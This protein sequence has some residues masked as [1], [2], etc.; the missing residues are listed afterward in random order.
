[1]IFENGI[2][3]L[4]LLLWALLVGVEYYLFRQREKSLANLF[5]AELEP[6]MLRHF[7]RKIYLGKRMLFFVALF[8]L[9]LALA[10]PE[11]GKKEQI[12]TAPGIDIVFAVDVSKSMLAD[13]LRPN[14]LENAK[15]ALGLLAS[16]LTGNRLALV[17][18]AGSSFIECP[19]TAD[20]GALPIFLESLDPTLIPVPGT[21]IGGAIRSARLAFGESPNSKAL[22]LIT[23]GEE[24]AGSAASEADQAARAGVKIFPVGIGTEVGAIV[25]DE[26]KVVVSK[27][28]PKLLNDLAQKTGGKAFFVGDGSSSLPQLMAAVAAL[29]KNK[30]T[31][32]LGDQYE[33]RFQIF[34]FFA[35]V[36]LMIE[37]S[38]SERRK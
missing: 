28:D 9:I 26:P 16:Q 36:C 27:L 5:Q 15:Q 12:L 31:A 38:L 22:I 20:V 32:K 37:S 19:L 6:V 8:F 11:W 29:P 21:D 2:I 18:F 25:P 23:D 17:A 4:L 34:I 7:D 10:R 30:L 3:L 35:L 1:M 13:D 24:L 33:D 14:R